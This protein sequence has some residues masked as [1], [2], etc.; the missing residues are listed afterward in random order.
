MPHECLSVGVL[1]A[2]HMCAPLDRMPKPGELLVNVHSVEVDLAT[3]TVTVTDDGAPPLSDSRSFAITVVSRP[4]ITGISLTNDW[5][6][7][8]WTTIPGDTYRLQFTTNLAAPEWIGTARGRGH[9]RPW[10]R[11]SR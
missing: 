10:R 6:N 7:V 5:V 11:C 9:S 3:G 2:D 8:T 1:V 4:L